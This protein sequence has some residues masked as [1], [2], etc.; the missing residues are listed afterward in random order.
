MMSPSVELPPWPRRRWGWTIA[1]VFAG[2]VSLIFWLGERG[3]V[4]SRPPRPAPTL[5]LAGGASHELLALQ[6]P[7]LFALPHRRGFSGPAWLE[8]PVLQNRPPDWSEEARC[9][10]LPVAQLGAGLGQFIPTNSLAPLQMPPL[11]EPE[12]ALFEPASLPLSPEQSRLRVEGGLAGRRLLATLDLPAWQH[13]DVLT[14]TIVQVLVNAEGRPVSVTLLPPGSGL[15]TADDHALAQ[16]R[17]ARFE[18]AS[19]GGQ[20]GQP[21]PPP[22]AHLAWGSLVFEW[23]T[24]PLP[25]TNAP[26]AK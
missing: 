10:P 16:A 13:S 20:E 22:L 2:Q 3:P 8:P 1:L 21:L 11:G 17:T 14:N 9:L 4:R 19:A 5:R 6:D 23:H 15:T 18:P 26:A 25:P 7:T 24:L 12:W